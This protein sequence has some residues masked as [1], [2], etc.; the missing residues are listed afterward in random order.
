M[1]ELLFNHAVIKYT[2]ATGQV[3]FPVLLLY[4]LFES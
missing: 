4:A 1:A 2:P 3:N